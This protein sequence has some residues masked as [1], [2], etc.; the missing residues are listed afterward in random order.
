L[1][2]YFDNQKPEGIKAK[3]MR[4]TFNRMSIAKECFE[5][6]VGIQMYAYFCSYER[7]IWNQFLLY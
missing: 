7:K 2:E 1:T 3:E 4:A 5:I 6:W